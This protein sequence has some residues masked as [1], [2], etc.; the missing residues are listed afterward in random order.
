MSASALLL[1]DDGNIV[2]DPQIRD[3]VLLPIFLVMFGQ[4]VSPHQ[5]QQL[6][7]NARASCR[8]AGASSCCS[9]SFLVHVC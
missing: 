6:L 8:L 4:G 5:Q 7:Q 1:V 3:W 2:L 9:C